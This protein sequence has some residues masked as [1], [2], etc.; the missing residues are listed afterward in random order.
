MMLEAV[1]RLAAE[2]GALSVGEIARELSTTPAMTEQLF[3]E[4]ARHGYLEA[5]TPAC[6]AGCGACPAKGACDLSRG[7]RLWTLTAKGARAC[8]RSRGGVDH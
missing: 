1:L 6:G 8:R 4:L 3:V 7:P 2:R 5:V